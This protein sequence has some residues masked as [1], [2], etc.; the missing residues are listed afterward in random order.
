MTLSRVYMD[1][2]CFI[3]LAK[4]K[5]SKATY[6]NGA[7][8][9]HLQTLLRASRAGKVEVC[10][11]L[12]SVTE[13]THA[14]GDISPK[15]QELFVGIL[16]SGKG[17][18]TLLQPDIWIAERARDLRWKHSINMKCADGIHVA[19]AIENNCKEFLTWDGVGGSAKSILKNATALRA[20]GLHVITPDKTALIPDEFKQ[21]NMQYS[22]QPDD[23]NESATIQ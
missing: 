20:L 15:I 18:V 19:S 13:C 3:E 16:T 9:W 12:L 1:S 8:I 14:E 2:C 11:S 17:G 5:F 4:G 6:D 22:Q 23:G 10:T 7:Y 21:T